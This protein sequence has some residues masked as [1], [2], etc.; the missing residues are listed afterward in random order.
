MPGRLIFTFPIA[1]NLSNIG[2]KILL[3]LEPKLRF[4]WAWFRFAN[5]VVLVMFFLVPFFN[6]LR[7]AQ[8]TVFVTV[9]NILICGSVDPDLEYE[10]FRYRET[11][12]SHNIDIYYK[13]ILVICLQFWGARVFGQKLLEFV[14]RGYVPEIS[15]DG[16][17]IADNSVFALIFTAVHTLQHTLELVD[18]VRVA[19][20][21]QAV[22]L[23]DRG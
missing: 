6:K 12:F 5:T 10:C 20:E 16:L 9:L 8:H 4:F 11:S 7:V 3:P 18:A 19:N 21:E 23:V 2:E 15:S 22:F 1:C 14:E 17:R 13:E